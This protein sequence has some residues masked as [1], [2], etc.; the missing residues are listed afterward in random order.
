MKPLVAATDPAFLGLLGGGTALV[1][2]IVCG[3]F[4]LVGVAALVAVIVRRNAR[5]G[6]TSAAR[7]SE[8]TWVSDGGT[9]LS[10]GVQWSSRSETG[11]GSDGRG[12]DGRGSDGR[13]SDGGDFSGGGGSDGGGSPGD[14]GGGGGGGGD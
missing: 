3:V 12:S 14:G 4:V 7:T 13:G 11:R 2:A 9:R 5:A 8:R 6:T 1:L 10:T